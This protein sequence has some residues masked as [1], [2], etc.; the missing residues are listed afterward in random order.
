MLILFSER[1]FD[2]IPGVFQ[3]IPIILVVISIGVADFQDFLHYFLRNPSYRF[4]KIKI[5]SKHIRLMQLSNVRP[6]CP[7]DVNMNRKQ[8]LNLMFLDSND[9]E[10]PVNHPNT[11]DQN[12][13]FVDQLGKIFLVYL[14]GL[15]LGPGV[16]LV[17]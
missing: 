12:L 11:F 7:R 2:Q 15:L 1:V 3:G 14:F 5:P 8:I 16:E 10:V 6:C 13:C 4:H 17:L 9:R